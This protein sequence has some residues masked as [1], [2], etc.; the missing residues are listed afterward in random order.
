MRRILLCV[1][2]VTAP[3]FAACSTGGSGETACATPTKTTTVD[4]QGLTFAP[5]CVSATANDTLSLVN[6]DTTPHTFT[7]KGTSINVNIEAGQTGQAALAG[8]A[9]GTYSVACT[10]HPTMTEVLQVT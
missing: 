7:V 6:H 10:Y 4:M 8:I 2:L 1:V 3:V 5:A 9:P